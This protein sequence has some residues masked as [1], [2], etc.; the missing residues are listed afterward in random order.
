LDTL[1]INIIRINAKNKDILLQIDEEIFDEKVKTNL[2]SEYVDENNHILLVA[3]HN[4]LVIGQVLGVVH[5]H[6]NKKTELYIDDLAV[7]EK[8]QRKGIATK[9]LNELYLIG[10]RKGCKEIWVATEPKNTV[11]LKFYKSMKLSK[12]TVIV[13]EGTF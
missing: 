1:K 6:P 9:L 3:I 10:K 12:R 11:A 7:S 8:L 13:F 4:N 5:K 2:L